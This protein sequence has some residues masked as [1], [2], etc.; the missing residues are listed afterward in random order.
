MRKKREVPFTVGTL[1][2]GLL[3]S[4]LLTVVAFILCVTLSPNLPG[5]AFIGIVTF[6]SGFGFAL[7]AAVWARIIQKQPPVNP[8]SDS[9]PD[10]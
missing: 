3:A 2:C 7:G 6:F 8:Q 9:R 1:L 4:A 5:F 10:I